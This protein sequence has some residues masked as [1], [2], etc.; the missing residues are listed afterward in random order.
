[1]KFDRPTRKKR[2]R[3]A[4]FE[5]PHD[6]APHPRAR[7]LAARARGQASRLS[8]DE[9]RA[10]TWQ[11]SGA[12]VPGTALIADATRQRYSWYPRVLYADV[13]KYCATCARPFLFYAK[14]QRFW[15]ETLQLPVDVDC[16]HCAPCRKHLHRVK[17]CLA[18]YA[19]A[20]HA[21]RLDAKDMK[22]FVDDALFLFEQGR[23][24]NIARLGAI[25]NR[26]QRELVGYSGTQALARALA[27]ARD[28]AA[29]GPFPKN[30]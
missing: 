13:L 26:A 1:M 27:T 30:R 15:F 14:E 21:P 16:R 5:L 25:K 8:N 17:A 29:M 6:L 19:T 20:L 11:M 7:Q 24:R 28:A 23:L 12:I 18:R 4:D 10:R 3:E 2:H 22:M 9:I